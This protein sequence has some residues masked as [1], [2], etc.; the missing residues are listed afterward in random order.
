MIEILEA[1]GAVQNGGG[2]LIVGVVILLKVVEIEKDFR[3]HRHDKVTGKP[4]IDV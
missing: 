2:I 3:L 4:V 1:L